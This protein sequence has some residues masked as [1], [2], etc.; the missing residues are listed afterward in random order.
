MD[1]Q[2]DYTDDQNMHVGL[3][4]ETYPPEVNGVAMTLSRL[5]NGLQLRGHAVDIYRPAQSKFDKANTEDN[6]TL[7]PGMPVPGYS[8]MHF[9]FPATRFF[10]KRWLTNRPDVLYV[11]TEGPLGFSAI[12][13]A[14]KL[15][16]PVISGFHTNFHSYSNHYRIGWLAP[17]IFSYLRRLHNKTAMTLVPTRALAEHLGNHGFNN[18]T[19]MQR[20]VD[21]GLFSPKRRDPQLRAQWQ[22]DEN[23]KVNL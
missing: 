23:T 6:E 21:T 4:T 19:V 10:K 8:E 3:V 9:G 16:I 13:V 18:V 2:A 17:V 14:R 5:V 15:G 12:T 22:A 1:A 7:M 11:A 20:G